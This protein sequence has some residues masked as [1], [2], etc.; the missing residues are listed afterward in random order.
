MLIV[1]HLGISQSERIV[2]LCEEL[3]IPY[4]LKLYKRDP[5]TQSAPADYKALHPLGT[6]PIITDGDLVL[7][8]SGAIVE[9]LIY[10]YGDGRFSV[11]QNGPNYPD[12]LFWVHFI[13]ATLVPALTTGMIATMLGAD[14]NA[15]M[16]RG[17]D[18]RTVNAVKFVDARLTG[19]AYLMGDEPTAPDFLLVFPLTTMRMFAP[20][21]LAPYPN[22]R[23]YLKRVAERPAYQ[24]AI[25][26][27]EPGLTPMAS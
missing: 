23:A 14:P 24:R 25:A 4:T 5:V 17:F 11:R 18:Q 7:P 26:K 10:K 8:E 27:S 6:A 16:R 21:D 13:N 9:H 22:I 2:W 19:R 3:G 1:H 20:L 15:P 12:Y